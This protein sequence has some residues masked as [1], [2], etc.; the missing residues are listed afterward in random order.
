MHR[1]EGLRDECDC[2]R[3]H[4]LHG[5]VKVAKCRHDDARDH[6]IHALRMS[7]EVDAVREGH[8]VVGDD[9][10]ETARGVD[11][12]DRLRAVGSGR[13]LVARVFERF[14]DETACQPIIFGN[15]NPSQVVSTSA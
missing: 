11:A 2:T 12:T 4:R 9:G 3:L 6:R 13:H 14:L 10:V 7:D 5:E 1:F 15:E 8:R